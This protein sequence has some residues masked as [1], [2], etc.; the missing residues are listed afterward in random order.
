M[1]ESVEVDRCLTIRVRQG[2]VVD[3]VCLWS[4]WSEIGIV[5]VVVLRIGQRCFIY[6][7]LH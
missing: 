2:V 5:F 6:F 4:V 7:I 1:S 3:V